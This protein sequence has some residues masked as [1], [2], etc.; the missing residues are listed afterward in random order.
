MAR[1]HLD[2]LTAA[3][4]HK[5]AEH[6]AIEHV[7]H[8]ALDELERV[9]ARDAELAMNQLAAESVRTFV[10]DMRVHFPH[11]A[12]SKWAQPTYRKQVASAITNLAA[13][14]RA[15][16]AGPS[17][18]PLGVLEG[19]SVEGSLDMAESLEKL[20]ALTSS[21]QPV[22]LG[23][24]A[25]VVHDVLITG[26]NEALLD[27][28]TIEDTISR[29]HMLRT[30][31][32]AIDWRA[33]DKDG[34]VRAAH[35][36]YISRVPPIP[37]P[38]GLSPTVL[39]ALAAIGDS[40]NVLPPST[41]AISAMQALMADLVVNT[42]MITPPVPTSLGTI[43]LGLGGMPLPVLAAV[44]A[45]KWPS[46]VARAKRATGPRQTPADFPEK[47][48]EKVS[49]F[50]IR[51]EAA[52]MVVAATA[53]DDDGGRRR[54]LTTTADDD[55]GDGGAATTADAV[56][57]WVTAA[58]TTLQQHGGRPMTDYL[59]A[60]A[61]S[62]HVPSV[63]LVSL[64]RAAGIGG[65][66]RAV[67]VSI[68]VFGK[69]A[70]S[71]LLR[72]AVAYVLF[73]RLL[74]AAYGN[75][76][77]CMVRPKADVTVERIESERTLFRL[78]Y[79]D[80]WARRR[81]ATTPPWLRP[82]LDAIDLVARHGGFG[83]IDTAG[84]GES[85]PFV[86]PGV[87]APLMVASVVGR[88]EIAVAVLTRVLEEWRAQQQQHETA[89]HRGFLGA[90][91][92]LVT[93]LRDDVGRVQRPADEEVLGSKTRADLERD[94]AADESLLAAVQR[95]GDTRLVF[96]H[97]VVVRAALDVFTRAG[98][99]AGVPLYLTLMRALEHEPEIPADTH[100][101]GGLSPDLCRALL[102]QPSVG[103]G[104]RGSVVDAAIWLFGLL[105]NDP[106]GR[107]RAIADR[108]DADA[109]LRLWV[110]VSARLIADYDYRH[111][112]SR[113]PLLEWP[114][115]AIATHA[116]RVKS[117]LSIDAAMDM[118]LVNVTYTADGGGIRY[119]PLAMVTDVTDLLPP[120][121]L[122]CLPALAHGL[123][124]ALRSSQ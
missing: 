12:N 69:L 22:S 3:E 74:D 68:G 30:R 102:V 14:C 35:Q 1:V 23:E 13:A 4:L 50:A 34:D 107:I 29:E 71:A 15:F 80:A 97:A 100:V 52:R 11:P 110:R 87:T 47:E 43:A 114:R 31:G 41:D 33:L 59:A 49:V 72:A 67:L 112:M 91:A 48:G 81:A 77:D 99:S 38:D 55:D 26:A 8:T 58:A 39:D 121:V 108:P 78:A 122:H 83:P 20:L 46:A 24:A 32:T 90:C 7:R 65:S 57:G 115:R 56:D 84:S 94:G 103:G 124:S 118:P 123:A 117:P 82:A 119:A 75:A 40:D 64:L 25:R 113:Q 101:V 44:A 42:H 70:D 9:M 28:A 27:W 54:R 17:S 86:V 2:A 51:D 96:A 21:L 19:S 106:V 36:A 104:R 85:W 62:A 37:P 116:F 66:P 60:R 6:E 98:V 5:A 10:D 53:V 93:W 73:E 120:S 79:E 16:A 111:L 45:G 95:V 105:A 76:S 88:T 89:E 18:P 63:S 109:R 61:S 92:R